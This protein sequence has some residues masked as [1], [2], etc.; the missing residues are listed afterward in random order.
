MNTGSSD[1]RGGS[2]NR[3]FSYDD[4]G[5]FSGNSSGGS[6]W[7]W[8]TNEGRNRGRS[9]GESISGGYSETMDYEVEPAAFARHLQTG[10]PAHRGGVTGVWFQAGKTFRASGR[11]YLPVSF[12]Q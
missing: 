12:K 5:N 4:K 11:N 2:F 9:T 8:G 3:G 7:N 1:G 10:G 6:S